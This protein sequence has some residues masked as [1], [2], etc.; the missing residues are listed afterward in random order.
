PARDARSRLRRR[1]ELVVHDRQLR[2]A[3]L[4]RL[5]LPGD[6]AERLLCG[7]RIPDRMPRVPEQ[8][9]RIGVEDLALDELR[10]V[11]LRAEIRRARLERRLDRAVEEVLP[12]ELRLRDPVP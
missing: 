7:I 6:A 2:R 8:A 11:A 10:P 4:L 9:R 1:L 3:V 12:R 5:G